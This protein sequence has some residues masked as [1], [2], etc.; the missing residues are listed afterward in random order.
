MRLVKT[1]GN[2]A[3]T[4][5]MRGPTIFE[6]VTTMADERGNQR[7]A[8]RNIVPAAGDQRHPGDS[9]ALYQRQAERERRRVEENS[10]NERPRQRT[11]QDGTSEP[12][13]E[14]RRETGEQSRS[15]HQRDEHKRHQDGR[16]VHRQAG[17]RALRDEGVI[18][19]EREKDVGGARRDRQRRDQRADRR[20]GALGDHRGDHHECRRDRHAE[21]EGEE[22]NEFG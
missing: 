8:Q 13:P 14:T 12:D 10:A 3:I 6:S 21:R 2:S 5:L 15:L 20:A 17:E 7:G 19:V 18:V 22:E 9:K 4:P 11:H 16:G 1:A